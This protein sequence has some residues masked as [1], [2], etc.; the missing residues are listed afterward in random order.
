MFLPRK[1][2]PSFRGPFDTEWGGGWRAMVFLRD[3][4]FFDSQLKRTIF[5]DLIKSKQFCFSVVEHTIF[6]HFH[7]ILQKLF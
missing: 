1:P 6:H 2:F 7:L 5:S 3:Q 4:T